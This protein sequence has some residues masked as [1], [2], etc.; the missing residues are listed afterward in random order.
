[1]R[2]LITFSYDGSNYSGYQKQID[3][4]TI[5]DTIEQV[6]TKVNANK[7][8]LIYASGRTDAHV[9]ALGQR[10]HFDMTVAITPFRLKKSLNSLLPNDIYIRSVEEVSQTFH[11]RYDV[12]LKEYMYIINIGE[13]N[14][15]ERNYVYQYNK[16]LD[17]EKMK[18][19]I[20][21]FIG[22]YNFKSF[23]KSDDERMDYTR[24]IVQASID[25]DS[26][27]ANHVIMSFLGT[28]FLRYM[29]RN[30]VG[31]LI[32]VGEGKR[33]SSDISV[34]LASENRTSAGKTAPPEG[35]YLKNVFY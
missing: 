28:G 7:P 9:H 34:I 29:V 5:Q 20:S 12:K 35:L 4:V 15:M 33:N 13:Y 31:T 14:P 24:T 22:T 19:A 2:Y 1:M 25:V 27:N 8:V 26:N 3:Q 16:T 18:E 10:A 21:F 30:M 23:T 32:E 11:A 17:I 6:L